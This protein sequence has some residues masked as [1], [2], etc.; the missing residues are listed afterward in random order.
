MPV[1]IL[2][3]SVLKPQGTIIITDPDL[4]HEVQRDAMQC[5]HCQ[6]VW[7][8]KPGSG[9]KRGFCTRCNRVTCGR[10]EC[11]VCLPFEKQCDLI[12]AGKALPV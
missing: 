9:I 2:R 6:A 3:H 8:V 1:A 12:E 5:V 4:P 10:P 7:I 11:D